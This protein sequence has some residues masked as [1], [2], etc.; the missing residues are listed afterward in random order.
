MVRKLRL[1]SSDIYHQWPSYLPAS[2]E[3]L[4]RKQAAGLREWARDS[5]TPIIAMGDFNFDYLFR[6][7]RGNESFNEFIF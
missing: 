3:T 7:Q 1:Q 6:K 2:Q 5:S 4:R